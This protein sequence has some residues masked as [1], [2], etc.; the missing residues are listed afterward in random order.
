MCTL[1]IQYCDGDI[2]AFIISEDGKGRLYFLIYVPEDGVSEVYD[3]NLQKLNIINIDDWFQVNTHQRYSHRSVLDM[4]AAFLNGLNSSY[5]LDDVED[6][7]KQSC[8]VAKD[9]LFHTNLMSKYIKIFDIKL[10]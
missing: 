8:N 1:E 4:S 5:S 2:T 9:S 3:S 7:V 6:I 10:V